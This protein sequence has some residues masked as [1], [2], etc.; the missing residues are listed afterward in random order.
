MEFLC[1][2]INLLVNFIDNCWNLD[3]EFLAPSLIVEIIES[4]IIQV[5]WFVTFDN[6]MINKSIC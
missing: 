4:T 3:V 6:F 5:L 2:Y 1:H